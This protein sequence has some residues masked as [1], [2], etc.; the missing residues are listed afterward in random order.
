MSN[1]QYLKD[2]IT[3]LFFD[4]L[5]FWIFLGFPLL[6]IREIYNPRI[7]NTRAYTKLTCIYINDTFKLQAED[8]YKRF[9]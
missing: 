9:Q 2:L 1:A 3:R 4:G 5:I 8:A 7:L 6:Q